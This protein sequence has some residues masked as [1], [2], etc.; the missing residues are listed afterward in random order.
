MAMHDYR[1]RNGHVDERLLIPAPAFMDCRFCGETA[2]RIAANRVAVTQP[3]ADLRGMYRR[4]TEA[5]AE[6]EHR[7]ESSSGLWQSAKRR[8]QAQIRAGENPVRST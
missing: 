8:A 5:S 6:M 2:E 1:C 4:F 7:G 3:E